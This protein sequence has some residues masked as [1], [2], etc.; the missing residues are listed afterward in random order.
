[1]AASR[2]KPSV[3]L[4][5]LVGGFLADRL[6]PGDHV[7]IGLSGGCDSVVLLHLLSRIGLGGRLLVVHV[8]HGLSPNAD[9]WT[10]FCREYCARLAVQLSVI[11]VQVDR[12]SGFGLEAAAR[13]ARY[14]A[15][16]G[17]PADVIVLAHHQGDLAE[18]VL[19]N[20]LRGAGVAGA[21]GMPA[22]RAVGGKR[23]LRPLLTVARDDLEVYAQEHGLRWVEDESNTDQHFSRN[24][25]RHDVLPILRQR[26]PAVEGSLAQAASHFAEADQLLGE[27]AEF[28]WRQAAEGDGES[29]SLPVLRQ[30]SLSRLKNLVRYRLRQLGW[31][32]PS[33][34]RLDEFCR[35]VL[36]AGPD[37][38]PE[39]LLSE[40]KMR[41]AQRK[42][43]WLRQ[44]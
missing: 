15:L 44:K 30:L 34:S 19:F 6:A 31:Q 40:G 39:L 4:T 22:E 41:V 24:Y 35:Q 43:H 26:F 5:G 14:A 25:L 36:T 1:M 3:D 18:T 29:A 17:C 8:N 42:L 2:N 38:H 7:C 21:A 12:Q 37:R 10:E 27:L 23:L 32:V 28:D 20:L 11:P 13:E 9:R 33:A 16:A